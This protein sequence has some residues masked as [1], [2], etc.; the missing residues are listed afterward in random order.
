MNSVTSTA[1]STSATE[2]TKTIV[3]NIA[4]NSSNV[5]NKFVKPTISVGGISNSKNLLKNLVK[6]KSNDASDKVISSTVTSTNSA[7]SSSSASKIAPSSVAEK[8]KTSSNALSLLA[9]YDN[10]SDSGNSD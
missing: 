7:T 9:G 4:V 6:K 2:N 10:D 1:P 5:N 3:K 8:P